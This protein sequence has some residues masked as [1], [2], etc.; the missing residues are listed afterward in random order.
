MLITACGLVALVTPLFLWV[1]WSPWLFWLALA[2]GCAAL[3]IVYVLI[4]SSPD[5]YL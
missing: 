4:W 5:E 2:T 1:A 3:L